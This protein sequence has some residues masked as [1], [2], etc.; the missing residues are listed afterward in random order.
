MWTTC[1]SSILSEFRNVRLQGAK[2]REVGG[3]CA[4]VRFFFVIIGG[5]KRNNDS[6]PCDFPQMGGL[7]WSPR[8]SSFCWTMIYSF[9]IY[10]SILGGF[11]KFCLWLK[12]TQIPSEER[13]SPQSETMRTFPQTSGDST[14]P[15]GVPIRRTFST[16]STND[17]I[18]Y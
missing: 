9:E 16:R 7:R 2:T 10:S 15:I 13:L 8:T 5:R 4:I 14:H 1:W 12:T 6:P 17:P 11:P 3:L 18:R